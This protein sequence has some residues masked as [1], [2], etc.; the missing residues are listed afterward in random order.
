LF[1]F[2][3]NSFQLLVQNFVGFFQGISF[4]LSPGFDFPIIVL[5]VDHGHGIPHDFQ[6]FQVGVALF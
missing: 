6:V 1:N 5:V 2:F 3:G 4:D